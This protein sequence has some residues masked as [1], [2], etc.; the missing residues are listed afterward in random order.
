MESDQLKLLARG[1]SPIDN[2]VADVGG[3]GLRVFLDEAEAVAAVAGLL[4]RAKGESGLR[5]RGPVEFCLIASDLPG[6]VHLTLGDE[7]PLNPQIRGAI[8]SLPGV[9]QVEEI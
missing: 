6:E 7:F 2:V 3:M 9:M 5:G 4:E 8:K 1:V